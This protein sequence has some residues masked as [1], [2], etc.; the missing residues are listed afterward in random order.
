MSLD[1]LA[2]LWRAAFDAEADAL[3]S[4]GRR[5]RSLGFAEDEL[6][7]HRSRLTWERDATARLLAAIAREN[8]F[9]LHR[10]VTSV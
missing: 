2:G 4:A 6:A 5:R 10:S 9:P 7:E 1:A 8:H 3:A